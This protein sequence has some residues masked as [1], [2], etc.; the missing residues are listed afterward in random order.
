MTKFG[1]HIKYGMK[2]IKI[3]CLYFHKLAQPIRLLLKYTKTDFEDIRYEQGDGM[4]FCS[5]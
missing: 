2:K 1:V 3:I 4:C 5:I